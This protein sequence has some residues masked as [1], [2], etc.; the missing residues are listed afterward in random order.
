MSG[1][2]SSNALN[3]LNWKRVRTGRLSLLRRATCTIPSTFPTIDHSCGD[4]KSSQPARA[5]RRSNLKP[6]IGIF[7]STAQTS[8]H[9]PGNAPATPHAPPARQRRQF[10]AAKREAASER[11]RKRLGAKNKAESRGQTEGR[12][13]V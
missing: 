6:A 2:T 8:P 3:L 5:W 7:S 11:M 4:G 12:Q 1:S 9:I 10:F 13:Q